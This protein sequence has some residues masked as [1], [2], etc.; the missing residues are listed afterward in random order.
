MAFV[1]EEGRRGDEA[2]MPEVGEDGHV[3]SGKRASRGWL[4]KGPGIEKRRK[5]ELM[6]S[7]EVSPGGKR[8]CAGLG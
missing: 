2:S 1:G 7:E 5:V 4:K 3:R 8:T 6:V